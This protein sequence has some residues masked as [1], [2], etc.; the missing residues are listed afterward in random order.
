MRLSRTNEYYERAV[1]P[2]WLTPYLLGI[3]YGIGKR[4]LKKWIRG[5]GRD[6]YRLQVIRTPR[7]VRILDPQL[8]FGPHQSAA[9]EQM[10]IFRARDM[11]TLLGLTKRWVNKL[12]DQGKLRYRKYGNARFFPV[13]EARRILLERHKL[14]EF[15]HIL[16]ER[17]VN[18]RHLG[19]RRRLP[20]SPNRSPVG[21]A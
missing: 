18:D 5:Q 20:T 13:S 2:K 3:K 4:A 17:E 9:P 8:E 7:G 15:R 14:S 11:A 12:A 6:C 16:L 1:A 21:F 19:P 10:F